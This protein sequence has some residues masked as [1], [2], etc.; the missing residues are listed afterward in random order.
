MLL[1]SG[2][3]CWRAP[4]P[5]GIYQSELLPQN[6]VVTQ[7]QIQDLNCWVEQGQ[8]FITG[9]CSNETASWQKIW[10]KVEPLDAAGKP[11]NIKG[12]AALVAPTF[13]TAVAPRGRTAFFSGWPVADFSG[14]PDSCRIS[15]AGAVLATAGPILLVEQLSGVKMLAPLKPG[16]EA[17]EEV[18]WQINAILNN[19]LP[20][21]AA[22]PRL[23]LLLYGTDNR[24]W[25]AT[26]LDPENPA[27]KSVLSLEK[28]G[29]MQAGEK[30]GFG[31]YAFYERMPE[32]LKKSKIGRVEVLGFEER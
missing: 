24:L 23:E 20:L 3:A 7:I 2:V 28:P 1:C 4:K 21:V 6:A 5:A 10:L 8:F 31:I 32:A 19:P 27:S 16:A 25:Y 15:C 13:S 17:T 22:H 14:M 18:A 12:F 9:I 29:P 30:R 26:L 11:L